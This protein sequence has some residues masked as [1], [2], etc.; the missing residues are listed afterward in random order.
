MYSGTQSLN[1]GL[2]TFQFSTP[3]LYNG[4]DN[5]LL[6]IVDTT[7]N[8]VSGNT[9]RTHTAPFTA[10]R[11]AY[12]STTLYSTTSMPTSGSTSTSRNNV[13]FGSPCDTLSPCV[14]P[15]IAISAITNDGATVNWVAGY[16]ESAWELEYRPLSDTNWVSLGT[17][18]SLSEMLTGLNPNTTYKVRMRSDCGSGEYSFWTEAT[19]TTACGAMTISMGNPWTENFENYTGSTLICWDTPRTFT[20]GSI[21][22]I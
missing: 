1:T 18:Y 4:S 12:S 15:S 22:R 9:W 3:F 10:T 20:N 5:L 16:T 6:I 17:V 19:F 7:G 13:I 11:Y 21:I 2:N 14:A 8:S